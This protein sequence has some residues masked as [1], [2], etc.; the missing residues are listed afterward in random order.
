MTGVLSVFLAS[1]LAQPKYLPATSLIEFMDWPVVDLEV[2][3]EFEYVFVFQ[4]SLSLN[5]LLSC[6]FIDLFSLY[7]KFDVVEFI[8]VYFFTELALSDYQVSSN[9]GPVLLVGIVTLIALKS[10]LIEQQVFGKFGEDS[11]VVGKVEVFYCQGWR[12]WKKLGECWPIWSGSR[13]R[14]LT[15]Q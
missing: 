1:K 3:T 13:T 14:K 15:L 9:F 6:Y 4:A 2:F 8:V 11:K 7:F 10:E 12:E 5:P